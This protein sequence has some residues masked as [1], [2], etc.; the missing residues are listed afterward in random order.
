MKMVVVRISV[1]TDSSELDVSKIRLAQRQIKK[2]ASGG[3]SILVLVDSGDTGREHFEV[4]KRYSK[5]L[6]GLKAEIRKINA[7]LVIAALRSVGIPTHS[8]PLESPGKARA[9]L[10]KVREPTAAVV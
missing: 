4:A 6:K 8:L 9:F 1:S 3:K 5:D 10:E 2:L 7:M